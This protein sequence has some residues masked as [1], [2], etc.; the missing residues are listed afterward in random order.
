M[1]KSI[2]ILVGLF[3]S[4]TALVLMTPLVSA[5]AQVSMHDAVV[6]TIGTSVLINGA[7]FV[8]YLFTGGELSQGVFG[9]AQ[10]LWVNRIIENLFKDNQFVERSHSE[11]QYVLG[12]AVVHLPMAGARPN[13]VKN[14]SSYPGVAVRRTDSDLTYPLDVYTTDPIHIPLAEEM[15]TSYNKM[16]N[17]LKEHKM[18]LAEEVADNLLN[19]WAAEGAAQIR[20]TTGSDDAAYNPH[21]TASVSRKKFLKEDLKAARTIMNKN[22]IPKAGR[23]ALLPTEFYDQ[24]MEDSD[25]LKRDFQNEVDIKDGKI[26]RLYG[27]DIMERSEVLVYDNQATPVV[28]AVGA[29]DAATDNL[30]ALCWQEDQV[31][32][33]MGETKFFE[34]KS[35][36]TYYG[37]VYSALLKMGGRKKRTTGVVA[38]V[39]DGTYS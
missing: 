33:A 2:S 35:D 37:D 34:N 14:R 18:A 17:V 4:L 29:A 30:A 3:V 20:R 21:A 10:E 38:I 26:M 1:K 16:D 31:T 11:D 5:A 39:Q 15:E 6:Y 9:V 36:A 28:K 27:F 13:V 8:T 23:V 32:R 22:K 19:H 24:L 25:L 7:V 12:G